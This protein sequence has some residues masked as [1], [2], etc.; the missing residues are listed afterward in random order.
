MSIDMLSRQI[1]LDHLAT[2]SRVPLSGDG[3][4]TM[5]STAHTTLA[6]NT[7]LIA[8]HKEHPP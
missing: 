1:L 6:E 3:S 5:Y 4:C 8:A 2:E 7:C